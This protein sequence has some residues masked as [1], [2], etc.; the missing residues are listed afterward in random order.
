MYYFLNSCGAKDLL[1]LS[2]ED[3]CA[4]YISAACHDVGHVGFTNAYLIN[5][6]DPLAILYNDR[7]VLE[8]YHVSLTYTIMEE[9]KNN[10]FKNQTQQA[11]LN[12][13]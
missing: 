6:L 13:R 9:A 10:I 11:Y 8:N 12:M 7:S 5:T 1:K 2:A 4:C 3:I